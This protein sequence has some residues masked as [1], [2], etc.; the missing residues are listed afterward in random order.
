M[1]LPKKHKRMYETLDRLGKGTYS[2]V[3]KVKNKKTSSISALKKNLIS[4]LEYEGVSCVQLREIA[5]LKSC[6]HPNIIPLIWYDNT[7]TYM[8]LPLYQYNLKQY[9]KLNPYMDQAVIRDISYQIL[10]GVYYL[11]TNGIIH[12]DIKPQNI[13]IDESDNTFNVTLIDF[14]LGKHV[15]IWDK[16]G[17][18]TSLICTLWYRAPEILMGIKKYGYEVDMWSVGCVIA[19]MTLGKELLRG[20]GELDQLYKTFQLFGTP[21]E[22]SWCGISK[23][24]EYKKDIFPKWESTFHNIFTEDKYSYDHIELIENL[25]MMNPI[26]RWDAYDAFESTFY[27]D[28]SEYVYN[29]YD[30]NDLEKYDKEYINNIT[31]S[32]YSDLSKCLDNQSD[33]TPNMRVIL[34]DWLMD[35]AEEYSLDYT[36][37][38]MAQS[39]VDRYLL[40]TNSISRLKLQLLGITSILISAKLTE[41]YPPCISDYSY[42]TDNTYGNEEILK[43]EREILH[44][45]NMEICAVIPSLFIHNYGSSMKLSKKDTEM[46]KFYLCLSVHDI[47][48]MKYHPSVI[49]FCCCAY[50][51]S[52]IYK[53]DVCDEI[54][55]CSKELKQ[56]LDKDYK[57]HKLTGITN[58]FKNKIS[59][60][61][62]KKYM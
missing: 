49:S 25:L 18:R 58:Y 52:I 22:N 37:F 32:K 51:S 23:L 5:I 20:D 12:R 50:A 30:N 46:V 60:K 45:L 43:M 17:P 28:V 10:R 47:K 4:D 35:V 31:T 38:L 41:V 6:N 57:K 26:N 19:E 36:T 40:V 3:Y 24:H 39:I 53:D 29:K 7:L 56:F 16:D 61:M 9:I 54:T 48:L 42:I 62:L 2:I 59:P 44:R 27:D 21:D 15:D 55:Q 8:E 14:G 34:L 33:I 13:M 11:H 1:N